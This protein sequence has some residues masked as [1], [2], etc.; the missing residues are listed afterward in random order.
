MCIPYNII[1][2]KFI[3]IF[4]TKFPPCS[5]FK[6][7]GWYLKPR[8]FVYET[9][10]LTTWPPILIVSTTFHVL[11]FVYVELL[12]WH[13]CNYHLVAI[14]Q[15]AEADGQWGRSFSPIQT[16]LNNAYKIY[17]LRYW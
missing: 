4:R 7:I 2:F 1:I 8:S 11:L 12:Y 9:T 17:S 14:L 15:L 3:S 13:I 5:F 6:W 16:L 10:A